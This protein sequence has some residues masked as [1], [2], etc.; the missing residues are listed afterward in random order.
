MKH[1]FLSSCTSRT[2]S[3]KGGAD[4]YLWFLPLA[5]NGI[6]SSHERVFRDNH[7]GTFCH[8]HKKA[9]QNTNKPTKT[10]RHT[11]KIK[12]KSGNTGWHKCGYLS[13]AQEKEKGQKQSVH[14]S[15]LFL[16]GATCSARLMFLLK[17]CSSFLF[18]AVFFSSGHVIRHFCSCR[19]PEH[20]SPSWTMR[21]TVFSGWT[22]PTCIFC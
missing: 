11:N 12:Y 5:E 18:P 19:R 14:T 10:Q 2:T 1:I 8:P 13:S 9:N 22:T 6:A 7:C 20:A 15:A 21:S 3:D 16:G 4:L 17:K